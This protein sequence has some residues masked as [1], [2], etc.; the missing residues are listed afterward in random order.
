MKASHKNQE[1]EYRDQWLAILDN[2]GV[3]RPTALQ[4]LAVPGVVTQ[5]TKG[6]PAGSLQLDGS[7]G[8]VLM[9]N[10]SPIK[11]LR[12]VRGQRSFVSNMLSGDMTLMPAGG[13]QANGRGT[14]RVTGLI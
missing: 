13:C 1:A 2:N 3:R 5:M 10:L 7:P 4:V 14:V 8:N 9:V 12:Q 6:E 11:D